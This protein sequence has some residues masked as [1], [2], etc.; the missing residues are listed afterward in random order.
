MRASSG[1]NR[2][3]SRKNNGR[4]LEDYP[5][6]NGVA[7]GCSIQMSILEILERKLHSGL[8]RGLVG[9]IRSRKP[10]TAGR[11]SGTWNERYAAASARSWCGAD[12]ETANPKRSQYST[13]LFVP[14]NWK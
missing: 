2:G 5:R 7:D 1:S 14:S 6:G 13:N 8:N 4:D 11:A 3:S 9:G 12:S 10:I